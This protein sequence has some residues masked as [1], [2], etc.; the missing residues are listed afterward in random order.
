MRHHLPTPRTNAGSWMRAVA[1]LVLIVTSATAAAL[2]AAGP[3]FYTDDPLTRDPES[4]DASGANPY[5]V[6]LI[7]SL[8][9]N[10][11]VTGRRP[12]SLVRAGNFNTIDEIP[13]SGW[14][15]NRFGSRMPSIDEAARGPVAGPPP[16]ADH[17]TVVRQKSAGDAPGFT[18]RDAKGQTWFVSFDRSVEPR[19]R[20]RRSRHCHEDLLDA[21]LQPGGDLP[22]DAP[23]RAGGRRPGGEVKTSVRRA[24]RDDARRRDE[25]LERGAAHRGRLV[26]RSRRAGSFLARSSGRSSITARAPTI[27]TTSCPT[28]IVASSGR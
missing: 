14:F 15:T 9:Y 12:V 20:H 18:A 3:K 5:D 11:F 17:W 19:S 8:S 27:P 23:A 10:L 7:Y 16:A 2:T 4:Q 25:V 24:H 21:R 13:D 6:N 1:L 22:L 28:S 26:P